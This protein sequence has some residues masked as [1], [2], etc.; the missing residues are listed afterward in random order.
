MT[1]QHGAGDSPHAAKVDLARMRLDLNLM[2]VFDVV[3]IE[4]HVTRAAEQLDMTQSAVSNALNRLR[5]LF[6]DQLFVK[7]VRG[8]NPTPRAVALWPAIHQSIEDIYNTVIPA[9]FDAPHTSQRFRL[10]MVDL[11]ASLLLPRL[12]R[13]MHPIAPDASIFVMPNEPAIS[14]P[15]LMRGEIDFIVSVSPPRAAVLQSM[16]LWS[17][18][19][20]IVARSNHPLLK[21][22]LSLAQF[23]EAPQ[24]AVNLAG[25]DDHPSAIDDALANRG[26]VRNVQI[27]VNQFSVATSILL[28]SDLIAALPARFAITARAR[29]QIDIC[30]MPF[31]VPDV[32]MYL[33]WH[34]R[35]NTIAAQQW[36]KQ[37]LIHAATLLNLSVDEHAEELRPRNMMPVD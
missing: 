18:S 32:V 15:K 35:S 28:D 9:E 29:E 31:S 34:Q 19:Y 30:S 10:S 11:C 5:D 37:Q 17:E 8:V 4:R 23:C 6:K 22:P 33:S 26:L 36:F 1:A 2:R 3:M 24:L 27:T 14:G 13:N 16:P 25:E 7:A 21:Q 20:V 12:Y